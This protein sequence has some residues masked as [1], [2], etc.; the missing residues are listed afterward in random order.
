MD[1]NKRILLLVV[2]AALVTVLALAAVL[3]H[4]SSAA[5]WLSAMRRQPAKPASVLA[6]SLNGVYFGQVELDYAAPGDREI[7]NAAVERARKEGLTYSITQGNLTTLP[8]EGG[9]GK[10][11]KD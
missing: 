7:V 3:P 2:S 9:P 1:K 10:P 5:Q 8:Q 11:R 4:Q 6:A